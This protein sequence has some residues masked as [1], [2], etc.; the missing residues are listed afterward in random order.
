V[1]RPQKWVNSEEQEHDLVVQEGLEVL[2]VVDLLRARDSF[3][4][5]E[6]RWALVIGF[7][8]LAGLAGSVSGAVTD[9]KLVS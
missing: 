6:S 8:L 5:R 9:T 3:R 1:P 4:R 2:L 7:G